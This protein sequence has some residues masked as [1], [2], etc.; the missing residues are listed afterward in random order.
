MND[1]MKLL[2]NG[3][4][5]LLFRDGLGQVSAL[6]VRE[7]DSVDKAVS[8]WADFESE[9]SPAESVFDGPNRYCGCGTTVAAALTAVTEKVL[10]RR[11]PGR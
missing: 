11:L 7:K 6:A 10:F 4:K 9:L 2:D 3:W 1:V 8:R 5:V